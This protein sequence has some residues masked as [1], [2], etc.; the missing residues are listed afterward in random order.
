MGDVGVESSEKGKGSSNED[1]EQQITAL[2]RTK[3]IG[4]KVLQNNKSRVRKVLKWSFFALKWEMD[5]RILE[6]YLFRY[7]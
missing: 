2:G 1:G 3:P 6:V 4:R 5:G 7:N